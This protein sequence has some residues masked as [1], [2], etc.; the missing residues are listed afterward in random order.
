MA[1]HDLAIDNG[2]GVA[3][4]VDMVAA[5]Q[6]LVTISS[7]PLEPTTMFAGMLW[8]DTSVTPNGSIKMRNLANTAWTFPSIYGDDRVGEIAYYARP[9][10]PAGWLKANG[11]IVSRTTYSALFAA[12][13]TQ[14]GIGDGVNT[15]Q[16]PDLRGRF[17]RA[18]DDSA[19]VDPSRAFGSTQTD[20]VKHHSHT[21]TVTVNSG[22]AHA[23]TATTVAG[24]SHAHT[25]YTDAQGNHGHSIFGPYW[26]GSY[27]EHDASDESDRGVHSTSYTHG[28]SAAG[29]HGHN[30]T[31]NAGGSHSHTLTTSTDPGHAHTASASVPASGGVTGT[32]TRPTNVAML[33]CIR[34]A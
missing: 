29:N 17:V 18:W 28:S 20:D 25:A 24:G 12:I 1:Q 8:L 27:L 2:P 33:A 9:T 16:L 34:Y 10:P 15:F 21:V 11:A 19:G 13:G 4:R 6:A 31:V 30:I 3:V 7:G 23:H 32:E 26:T 22:G 5:L 14:F